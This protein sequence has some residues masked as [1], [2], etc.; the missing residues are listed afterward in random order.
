M[1]N[2]PRIACFGLGF[3]LWLTW[4]DG[5]AHAQFPGYQMDRSQTPGYSPY[6]N[7]LRG[8]SSPAIN[9]YGIVRPDITFG[10]SLYQ[11]GVQQNMLQGQQNQQNALT[12]YTTLP[13]TG[14]FRAGFMTQSRYFMSNGGGGQANGF[15]QSG[16]MPQLQNG[17]GVQLQN[18]G[19][20]APQLQNLGGPFQG[21]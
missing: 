15:A 16:Y 6:L 17:G 20:V 9:Y 13:P 21:R 7:I 11:L 10:N 14:A 18:L 2:W 3:A 4:T 19:G 5:S 8:G 12:A 1:R